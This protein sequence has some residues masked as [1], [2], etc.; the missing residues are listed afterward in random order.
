MNKLNL[1]KA[2]LG[3]GIFIALLAAISGTV[4]TIQLLPFF[5]YICLSILDYEK[6]KV[7][8][9]MLMLAGIMFLINLSLYSTVDVIFWTVVFILYIKE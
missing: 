3:I 9:W 7:Q 5:I 6:R 8:I 4:T 1:K 2:V